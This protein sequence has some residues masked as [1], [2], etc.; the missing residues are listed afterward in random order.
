VIHL[1]YGENDYAVAEKVRAVRAAF[2]AK[3]GA[4][5]IE[6]I[7]ADEAAAD[8]LVGKLVN[9]DLFA[10]RKLVIMSGAARRPST[11]QKLAAALL[12]VPNST[13]VIMIESKLDGRLNATKEIKKIAGA[14]E[15]RAL[16]SWE[17]ERWAA[18]EA[19]RQRLEVKGAALRELVLACGGDQWRI[20]SEIKKLSALGQVLTPELVKKYV[21]SVVSADA[22]LVLELALRRERQAMNAE[23]QKLRAVESA[24][25]FLGLFSAQ[26]F[27]L[28]VAKSA[29]EEG[30]AA[31]A[32]ATGVHPF[33]MQKTFAV[34]DEI[35]ESELQKLA[36]GLAEVDAK[37]KLGGDG[38]QLMM[39][40]LNRI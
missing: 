8:D 4:E 34:R 30:S 6:R 2:A 39:I 14:T 27:A 35:S 25:K 5:A 32:K 38:W 12:R 20:A 9:V 33:V 7:D 10:S 3:Y 18:E 23:L 21:E 22:F 37:M 16:R 11:W 40:L 1:Y 13:E 24:E 31:A 17:L 19:Q 15:F 28:A 29:G 26:V 36:A